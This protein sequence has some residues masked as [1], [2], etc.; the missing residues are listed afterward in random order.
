M[1]ARACARVSVFV[2]VFL[3][4]C[5]LACECLTHTQ[6]DQTKADER[7][8]VK[9]D[10]WTSRSLAVSLCP[11]GVRD[12]WQKT[13]Q[14][15]LSPL[16]PANNQFVFGKAE[17][18]CHSLLYTYIVFYLYNDVVPLVACYPVHHEALC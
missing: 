2:H 6:T 8:T 16:M 15:C 10:G 4:V 9:Q 11:M 5:V 7:P 13:N 1:R 18:G 12:G 14:V 17:L 3:S